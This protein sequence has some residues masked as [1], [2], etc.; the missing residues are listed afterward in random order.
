MCLQYVK[1]SFIELQLKREIYGISSFRAWQR[2]FILQQSC[3]ICGIKTNE[4]WFVYIETTTFLKAHKILLKF[5]VI[6][7]HTIK[8]YKTLV[9][10]QVRKLDYRNISFMYESYSCIT[11][12][13]IYHEEVVLL[14]MNFLQLVDEALQRFMTHS[15]Q[16]NWFLYC[17][18]LVLV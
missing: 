11:W 9:M 2:I 14:D 6:V 8:W 5:M 12:I 15:T 13:T 16:T 7:A 17:F 1:C 10:I 3:S 18:H 4:S